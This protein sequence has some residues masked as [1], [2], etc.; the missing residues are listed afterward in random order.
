VVCAI[1]A[2]TKTATIRSISAASQ[3]TRD[4]R[5]IGGRFTLNDLGSG[6]SSFSYMRRLPVDYLKI[7]CSLVGGTDEEVNDRAIVEAINQLAHRLGIEAVA[8]YAKT[9][10]CVRALREIDVDCA[11]GIALGAVAPLPSHG[12][13]RSAARC[14]KR[15]SRLRAGCTLAPRRRTLGG[16]CRHRIGSSHGTADTR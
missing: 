1:C 16:R 12:R 7:D 9:P 10:D 15:A 14:G 5:D 8:V 11:Q 2:R 4:V 3:L 6:L 13:H